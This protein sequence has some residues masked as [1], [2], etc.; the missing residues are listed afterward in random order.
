MDEVVRVWKQYADNLSDWQ[1]VVKGTE[2][3]QTQ[4]GPV[5]EP[6]S[7]LPE[8]TETFAISDM[9][10]VEVA[11]PHY[12]TNG[13]T[14][15][16]FVIQGSG[17]TVVGGEEMPIEQD[18]VIV[19]PPNTTH[20]TIPGKDLV[21]VVINTPN[22]NAANIVEPTESDPS[23]KFNKAQYERLKERGSSTAR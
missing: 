13:E 21:M 22:F 12:H 2:P 4:C 23:T 11:Y 14:E 15:I 7:P 6:P 19:T 18:S 9:R 1:E 17:L 5:Y 3:K 16:Y 10:N 8:R 20:F